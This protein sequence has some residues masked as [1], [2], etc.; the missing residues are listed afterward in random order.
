MI[1]TNF[2]IGQEYKPAR[3]SLIQQ[4]QDD[5]QYDPLDTRIAQPTS[6]SPKP[7]TKA[8]LIPLLC[9]DAE[10]EAKPATP[11]KGSVFKVWEGKIS[12]GKFSFQAAMLT[13]EN[14]SNY[15]MSPALSPKIT[16]DGRAKLSPVFDYLDNNALQLT[17]LK[18]WVEVRESGEKA[19]TLERA[20]VLERYLLEMETAEK[21]GV[22]DIKEIASHLY[23][24]P[25]NAKTLPFI[26]KWGINP[27]HDASKGKAKIRFAYFFAFKNRK[28]LGVYKL[29]RPVA[30]CT[31]SPDES[32]FPGVP[33]ADPISDD[34]EQPE[35]ESKGMR[36]ALK[37]KL[38]LLSR[39]EVEKLKGQLSEK[40][41]GNLEELLEE[42]LSGQLSA[43]LHSPK[44]PIDTVE[45]GLL[46]YEGEIRG[47]NST[48]PIEVGHQ[49]ESY[50]EK[51]P[52]QNA[53]ILK[54]GKV[55]GFIDKHRDFFQQYV[56]DLTMQQT[57]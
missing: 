35:E 28:V 53:Y 8:V 29:M 37:N 32:V 45:R 56:S 52:M 26:Q 18:G 36:E 5:N 17:I 9:D 23:L 34:E 1:K 6:I 22:I 27:V 49:V 19:S 33:Q 12:T 40:N 46:D 3:S 4:I 16:I 31:L 50:P 10:V 55:Q 51:S 54:L 57:N 21:C 48:F 25:W 20:S 7:E 15:M 43:S 41:K 30:V 2:G 47:V 24:I 42:I 14:L 44:T 11:P 38:A 39:E 13:C